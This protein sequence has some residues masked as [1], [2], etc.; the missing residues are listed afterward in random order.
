[1]KKA[2]KTVGCGIGDVSRVQNNDGTITYSRSKEY[3]D[4]HK[5]REDKRK[6][7]WKAQNDENTKN[8][9]AKKVDWDFIHGQQEERKFR[10]EYQDKL[11]DYLMEN[12]GWNGV[13]PSADK[14]IQKIEDEVGHGFRILQ[15]KDGKVYTIK[16]EDPFE[17]I[18]EVLPFLRPLNDIGS[19]LLKE[20]TGIDLNINDVQKKISNTGSSGITK[21]DLE[22]KRLGLMKK[23]DELNGRYVAQKTL[24][25]G[26]LEEIYEKRRANKLLSNYDLKDMIHSHENH[27]PTQKMNRAELFKHLDELEVGGGIGDI[28]TPIKTEYNNMSKKTLQEFGNIP[29]ENITLVRTAFFTSIKSVLKSISS[30]DTLYHLCMVATVRV[31]K[32]LKQISIQKRQQIEITNTVDMNEHSETISVPFNKTLTIN[33]LLNNAQKQMGDDK[34]FKYS[35]INNNCQD[36]ITAILNSNH[37][38]NQEDR[39]FVKQ[40]VSHLE[41]NTVLNK[42]LDFITNLGTKVSEVVGRGDSSLEKLTKKELL[43]KFDKYTKQ[44]LIS[45]FEKLE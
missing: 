11:H 24:G 26:H 37:I 15:E 43:S 30:Y 4:L 12:W 22:E 29:I 32:I 8:V 5:A 6:A 33:E 18:T 28:F 1:M 27:K 3:V 42:G 17:R 19:K 34:Y 45:L 38:G 7:D 39:D 13:K 14:F 36:Y 9:D 31:G 2:T 25:A 44:E 23:N 16:D 20:K 35:A 41:K 21:E 10:K 40:D